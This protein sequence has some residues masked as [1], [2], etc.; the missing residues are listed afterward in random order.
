MSAE[1]TSAEATGAETTSAGATSEARQLLQGAV[2]THVHSSP[3]LVERKLDDFAVAR[4]ARERG[5]A[6]VVLK[7]HFLSTALRAQLVEQQ[8]PGIRIIGSLVL[9]QPMGGINPWAVE[10]AA[11]GGAKVVWLPTFQSENQLEHEAHGGERHRAQLSVKGREQ[12]VR[13]F[14]ADGT[15]TADARAVV[16]IVRDRGMVLASGHLSPDEVDRL[17]RHT[18]D[19]GLKRVILTHPDLPVISMP[20]DFQKRLT[21]RGVFFE[22][23]F[24][25]TRPPYAAL[26]MV[27]LAA[28]I[29]EVG[30]DST[31]LAT[32]FGQT[33]NPPPVEGLEAYVQGLLDAGFTPVEIR[34]MVGGHARAL[35]G[36]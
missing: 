35:L 26:T 2:D 15:L 24:N 21:E 10:A 8:V 13:V 9:N 25:V 5:M 30:V 34:P 16:E 33:Q 27:E 11:R 32:D 7:N 14:D 31:I 6:A 17:T 28:R 22:R 1:A 20:V 12:A 36:V 19:V 23:T 29:R 4:Q 18:Q 3:D